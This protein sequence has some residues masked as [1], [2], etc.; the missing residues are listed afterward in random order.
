MSGPKPVNDTQQGTTKA[1]ARR[2][3]GADKPT[4]VKTHAQKLGVMKHEVGISGGYVGP[5][6]L[7]G[8]FVS[9]G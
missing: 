1:P 2:V 7:E 6:P 4:T 5:A 3:G 8:S 9:T